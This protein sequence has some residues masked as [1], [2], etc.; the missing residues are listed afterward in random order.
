MSDYVEF[1]LL[2]ENGMAKTKNFFQMYVLRYT[3]AVGR[4]STVLALLAAF[5]VCIFDLTYCLVKNMVKKI[6]NDRIKNFYLFATWLVIL[7]DFS[8]ISVVCY[9]TMREVRFY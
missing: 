5:F 8:E 1:V 6:K 2:A 4:V 9:K 7:S 3:W